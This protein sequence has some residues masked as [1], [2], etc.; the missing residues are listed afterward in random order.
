M[1]KR[2]ILANDWR[3][4]ATVVPS[5]HC[6]HA[7]STFPSTLAILPYKSFILSTK[8]APSNSATPPAGSEVDRRHSG[9]SKGFPRAW[10]ARFSIGYTV[11]AWVCRSGYDTRHTRPLQF[12]QRLVGHCVLTCGQQLHTLHCTHAHYLLCACADLVSI[13]TQTS[14]R[15][16]SDQQK[17]TPVRDV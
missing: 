13:A 8:N 12:F 14:R 15:R 3:Q 16:S 4:N 2:A 7:A 17:T 1:A 11:G 6:S 5:P 9:H 10:V